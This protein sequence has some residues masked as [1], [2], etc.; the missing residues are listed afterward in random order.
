MRGNRKKKKK[1]KNILREALT[2]V[3]YL[4]LIVAAVYLVVN[5]VAERTEVRG[6]SMY[7]ALEDGDQLIVDLFSYHFTDPRRFDVIVFPF[8]YQEDTYYIKRVIGLP[9]ETVQIT[10]GVIYINGEEL[11]ESYGYE[12][13]RNPGLA[14]VELTLGEQEY[15]VLGDNRNDSTDSREPSVGNISRDEII[16]KAVLKIWPPS[17]IGFIR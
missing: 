13:I 12:A 14:S 10:D 3:L 17:S 6:D 1:K 9:G 8:Q 11:E 2:W 4:V 15:F 5:Y 16:G 7:P